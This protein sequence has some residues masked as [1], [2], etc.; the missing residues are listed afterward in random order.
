MKVNMMKSDQRGIQ[1]LIERGKQ[2]EVL[3]KGEVPGHTLNT[4][5]RTVGCSFVSDE[6]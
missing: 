5:A 3:R 4:K 6:K 2:A 1:A